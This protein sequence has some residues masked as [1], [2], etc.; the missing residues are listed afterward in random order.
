MANKLREKW[1]EYLNEVPGLD[2]AIKPPPE[3]TDDSDHAFSQFADNLPSDVA[4]ELREEF[5]HIADETPWYN[6]I[7]H[8]WCLCEMPEG[9]F[10]RVFAYSTLERL[11][12]A[13]AEREGEETAVWPMYGVPLRITQS[14]ASSSRKEGRVR[15]LLLPNQ[16]AVVISKDFPPKIIDQSL[17]PEHLE[18][19]D[20]GWLGD[21]DMLRDQG[22]FMQGYVEEE[23]FSADPDMDDDDDDDEDPNYIED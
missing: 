3:V 6:V 12:E 9:D 14:M 23:Q 11:A 21:P 10:P 18:I 15:Y 19:Q 4:E 1:E 17:L 20:E 2:D 13:I 16:V 22:Y 5:S 8:Q 7:D